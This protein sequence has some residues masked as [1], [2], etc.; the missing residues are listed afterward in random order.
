MTGPG[1]AAFTGRMT[2]ETPARTPRARKPRPE[3]QWSVDGREP[4]NHNEEFKAADDGFHVRARIEETYSREGFASIDPDDL[5]GRFRW[6]GLYTQRRPGIDGGRTG[7]LSDAEIEDEY[8][9]MRVRLDGGAMTREQLRVLAQISLE[10]ARGT[11]DITDRQNIQYHWIRIED[12]PEIWRRLEEVGLDTV[13]A[14]GD[15]PRV[16]LGSPVAGAAAD[17]ILDPT[18]AIDALR[19]EVRKLE[20]SN[21]PRKYK[22]AVTGHPSLDVA[23]EINDCSFVG[24]IHPELGPGYDLW[25]GG[26]LSVQPFLGLRLG[27]F[28]TEE[29]VV[30]VW[31]GVTSI[32]RDYGYRRLRNR[33]RMKFLVKDWGPEKLREVLETEYL[34]YQ[35]A[36]GPAPEAPRGP[37]DHIGVHPQKDGRNLLGAAPRAGRVPGEKLAEVAEIMER[38]GSDRVRLTP[39]QKIIVLDIADDDVE[40]AIE[41]LAAID[42]LVRPSP[43]RRSTVACTGIE[44][45]KLAIVETKQVASDVIDELEH[46]LEGVDLPDPISLHINGCPNSCA[47]FQVADIG[48]K[49]QLLPTPDGGQKP[50]YQVHLGG[51]LTSSEHGGEANLGR[52]VRGLKVYQDELADYVERLTRRF[53]DQRQGGESFAAW[54]IRAEEDELK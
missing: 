52:T 30:D 43:F 15:V 2:T 19:A 49:G 50:G 16:I 53:L 3:G 20:F 34:G 26:A 40:P 5:H 48:L 6:W 38:F 25:V 42:L 29:Q 44:F 7:S 27:A 54:S 10:F 35:L 8:F 47:R 41:A 21:L 14:C 45:C 4:L 9:M 22:T 18:P 13:S 23:H 11:S 46:R 32:F 33:A 36:D 31:R 17:E 39:Q 1:P 37:S 12:V 28:V 51:G 24:V